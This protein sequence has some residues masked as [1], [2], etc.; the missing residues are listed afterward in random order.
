MRIE[1]KYARLLESEMRVMSQKMNRRLAELNR[2]VSRHITS[3]RIRTRSASQKHVFWIQNPGLKKQIQ[4]EYNKL[5]AQLI[6]DT[7]NGTSMAAFLN[8]QKNREFLGD[9]FKGTG[10]DAETAAKFKDNAVF[11]FGAYASRISEISP[12][13]L[14][15]TAINQSIVETYVRAGI[16]NGKSAIDVAREM[17]K[18]HSNPAELFTIND[19]ANYWRQVNFPNKGRGVYKSIQKNLERITRT[20][21]NRAYHYQ[22]YLRRNAQPF[23][24]GIK[25]ELSGSHPIYDICD[26]M[27]G[28]Y[29]KTFVFLGWHPHC[30]CRSVSVLLDKDKMKGFLKTGSI[31][32]KDYTTRIP[33][34]ASRYVK[35]NFKKYKKLDWANN[36]FT[37]SGNIRKSI[38][39]TAR[40]KAP[41]SRVTTTKNYKSAAGRAKKN[42]N[43]SQKATLQNF[44]SSQYT[45]VNG[46][47]R[48]LK[49]YAGKTETVMP[50]I[51]ELDDIIGAAP[52]YNGKAYHAIQTP[53]GDLSS[54][55]RG[56]KAGDVMVDPGYLFG[57][58]E[59]GHISR[60]T[61]PGSIVFELENFTGVAL[62]DITSR[63]E[64]ISA[65][66][67]VIEIIKM[68]QKTVNGKNV[69]FI[70]AKIK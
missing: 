70:T 45:V 8:D 25:I 27:V 2:K 54:A 68:E 24:T 53:S 47:A 48:G 62:K 32:V 66:N 56:L 12:R 34:N 40:Q 43:N 15:Y 41:G 16:Y 7:M 1:E 39:N 60:F 51:A 63:N 11:A 36:N 23:V 28:K 26:E 14:E 69:T 64:L 5:A 37:K 3:S 61:K 4:K 57:G 20:E 35:D 19:K 10:I 17:K 6:R 9:Y 38:A 55:I 67:S 30:L 31:S 59:L 65:R 13:V 52:K 50:Q 49:K 21:M 46:Y 22:D 58:Q 33:A 18:L 42:L 29:P 44:S